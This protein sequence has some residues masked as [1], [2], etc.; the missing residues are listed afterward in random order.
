MT[1]NGCTS[2][3]VETAKSKTGLDKLEPRL[4]QCIKICF[5]T[6]MQ[7]HL[8]SNKPIIFRSVKFEAVVPP[9][10]TVNCWARAHSSS[11]CSWKS[12]NNWNLHQGLGFIRTETGVIKD[13]KN[14]GKEPEKIRCIQFSCGDVRKATTPTPAKK[15]KS[16]GESW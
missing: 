5:E 2:D 11:K 1:D 8:P 6:H 16:G 13:V 9:G 4:E 10:K 15:K 3:C 12:T 14:N 7:K